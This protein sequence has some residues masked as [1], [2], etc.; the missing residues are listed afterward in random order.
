MAK[1]LFTLYLN[2]LAEVVQL[3]SGDK[4]QL[5]NSSNNSRSKIWGWVASEALVCSRVELPAGGALSELVAFALEEDLIEP[6][7]HY[8]IVVPERKAKIADAMALTHQQM[9]RWCEAIHLAG[10]LPLGLFP[11]FLA[12]PYSKGQ[13]SLYLNNNRLLLRSGQFYGLATS[14]DN[15]PRLLQSEQIDPQ[16]CQLLV[17]SGCQV[18]ESLA[19]CEAIK[20][21]RF[22]QL[23]ADSRAPDKKANLYQGIYTKSKNSKSLSVKPL[24][25]VLL[26]ALLIAAIWGGQ[27]LQRNLDLA[28]QNQQLQQQNRDLLAQMLPAIDI[29]H[30]EWRDQALRA[31]SSVR[32]QG[33][34]AFGEEAFWQA[35][36]K[37]NSLMS[38]CDP[39]LIRNITYEDDRL[40]L[41]FSSYVHGGNTMK[42]RAEQLFADFSDKFSWS[43]SRSIL[44][45]AELFQNRI[46][47]QL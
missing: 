47:V 21:V 44:N 7:E 26:Y 42:A 27:D 1:Q 24:I 35:M 31:L 8:H 14:I 10:C 5:G 29:N 15:L 18:P 19:A 9:Q 33:E 40:E 25:P 23:L 46:I 16:Q 2:R 45:G 3:P 39:C 28:Q 4:L 41:S 22:W 34:S 17:E 20:E 43:S 30:P 38:D 32:S 12:L 36:S 37:V 13:S 11:D 6:I